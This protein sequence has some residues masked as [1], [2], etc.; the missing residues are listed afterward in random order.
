[1]LKTDFKD[2]QT[3]FNEKLFKLCIEQLFTDYCSPPL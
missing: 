2:T 1:M 3:Y